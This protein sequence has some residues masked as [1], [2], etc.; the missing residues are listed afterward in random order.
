MSTIS[1]EFREGNPVSRNGEG[2]CFYANTMLFYYYGSG[3]QCEL[4]DTSHPLTVPLSFR[5][6]SGS[7]AEEEAEIV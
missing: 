6:A 5:S 4:G 2:V 1:S 3:V 7:P